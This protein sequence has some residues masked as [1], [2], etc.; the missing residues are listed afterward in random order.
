[1]SQLLPLRKK[2]LRHPLKVVQKILP[3]TIKLDTKTLVRLEATIHPFECLGS[4]E[5]RGLGLKVVDAQPAGK[6]IAVSEKIISKMDLH[7]H[8]KEEYIQNGWYV[9][10]SD[11]IEKT[12][13]TMLGNA[14]A[15]LDVHGQVETFNCNLIHKI[16]PVKDGLRANNPTG[17]YVYIRTLKAMKAGEFVIFKKYGSGKESLP[18]GQEPTLKR[19][20]DKVRNYAANKKIC[21]E[22][23]QVGNDDPC[24]TCGE[25]MP[26][27]KSQ[28]QVHR[29]NCDK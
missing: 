15:N 3:G 21:Q 27:T 1:M 22:N 28:K 7:L 12:D 8:T 16:L 24:P 25:Q 10:G 9:F 2:L 18:W 20:L 19:Q 6:V 29:I 17:K 4:G 26:R 14:R 5:N 11:A 23:K 13:F